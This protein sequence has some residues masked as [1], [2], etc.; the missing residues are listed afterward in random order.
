[1][2]QWERELKGTLEKGKNE[3]TTR[4]QPREWHWNNGG[5]QSSLEGEEGVPGANE[6]GLWVFTRIMI[7]LCGNDRTED[8]TLR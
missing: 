3:Q 7:I 1:M 5:Y 6:A 4:L 2:V 8:D